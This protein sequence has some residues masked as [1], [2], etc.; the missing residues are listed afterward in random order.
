MSKILSIAPTWEET[1]EKI[2]E[3]GYV[4]VKT[5]TKIN[6]EYW[7]HKEEVSSSRPSLCVI[8]YPEIILAQKY[9]GITFALT[10]E[11]LEK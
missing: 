5:P 6:G 8:W 2:R 1:L 4:Y 3:Q 9:Y 11:E 10:K 7:I